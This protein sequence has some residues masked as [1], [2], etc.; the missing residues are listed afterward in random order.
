MALFNITASDEP[1]GSHRVLSLC[2]SVDSSKH[3]TPE[4]TTHPHSIPSVKKAEAPGG[5][6]TYLRLSTAWPGEPGLAPRTHNANGLV[7]AYSV[8]L[9]QGQV[10]RLEGVQDKRLQ[11]GEREDARLPLAQEAKDFQRTWAPQ[12]RD[13]NSV[14]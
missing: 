8:E 6:M 10:V 14:L 13:R 12:G 2:V 9:T 11:G 1:C 3:S 5:L 4:P 7:F